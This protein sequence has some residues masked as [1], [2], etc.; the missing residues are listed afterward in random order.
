VVPAARCEVADVRLGASAKRGHLPLRPP[1][2][3]RKDTPTRRGTL[4]PQDSASR[5]AGSWGSELCAGLTCV[6]TALTEAVGWPFP[7]AP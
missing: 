2:P 5:V 7:R 1:G 4:D 3:S 6:E